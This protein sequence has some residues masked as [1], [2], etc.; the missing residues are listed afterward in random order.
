MDPNILDVDDEEEFMTSEVEDEETNDDESDS[1]DSDEEE[2]T[3]EEDAEESSG[4]PIGIQRRLAKVTKAR[5]SAEKR[6]AEAEEELAR[7]KER[8]GESSPKV[9]MAIAQKHGILPQLMDKTTLQHICEVDELEERI[10][11]LREILDNMEDER[12]DEVTLNNRTYARGDLR[13]NL[14]ADERRLNELKD[15]TTPARKAL[16]K[17]MARLIELGLEAEKQQQ[18]KPVK[19]ATSKK[20]VQ[21][22][23]DETS[24]AK[25]RKRQL[26]NWTRQEAHA[27]E[28]LSRNDL[29]KLRRKIVSGF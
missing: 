20:R 6:A 27:A 9:M 1:E 8:S 12:Q 14:R 23:E 19:K 17:R 13:K 26:N 5:K 24:A 29:L 18:T 4:L 7:V 3:E 11:S 2:E 16:T 15:E 25:P 10:E 22:D 21:E 28:G